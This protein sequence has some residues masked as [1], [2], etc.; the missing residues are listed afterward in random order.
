MFHDMVKCIRN[1][2]NLEMFVFYLRYGG[3]K[4]QLRTIC[5]ICY[6]NSYI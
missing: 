2:S 4:A 1:A 5:H 3:I 6:N